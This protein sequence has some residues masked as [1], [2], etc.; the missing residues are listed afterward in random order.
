[1]LCV[2]KACTSDG[3]PSRVV[4]PDTLAM[5]AHGTVQIAA[6]PSFKS[7]FTG[8][9][10]HHFFPAE[11]SSATVISSNAVESVRLSLYGLVLLLAI[12]EF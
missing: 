10:G 4:T 11:F 2:G 8:T 9:T 7:V 3:L 6:K 5:F 1:V 12:V